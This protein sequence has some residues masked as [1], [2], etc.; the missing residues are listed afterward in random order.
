MAGVPAAIY[1]GAPTANAAVR[2]FMPSILPRGELRLQRLGKV[3]AVICLLGAVGNITF[4]TVGSQFRD[5]RL[6]CAIASLIRVPYFRLPDGTAT[7]EAAYYLAAN[8][9][10]RS[11]TVGI[12]TPEG[13]SIVRKLAAQSDSGYDFIV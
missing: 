6:A 3:I 4:S 8:R 5:S 11:V 1:F 2:F 7:R 13:Q 9:N 12:G 10:K